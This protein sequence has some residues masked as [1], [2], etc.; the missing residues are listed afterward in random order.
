MFHDHLSTIQVNPPNAPHEKAPKHSATRSWKQGPVALEQD[1]G[2]GSSTEGVWMR[3]IQGGDISD[4]LLL[5]KEIRL[6]TWDASNPVNNGIN[7]QPQ[8]VQDG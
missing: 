8:Q 7:D 4:L 1:P 6:T 2:M 3:S 5:M